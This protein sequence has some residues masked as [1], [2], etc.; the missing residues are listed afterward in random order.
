MANQVENPFENEKP[1]IVHLK[2]SE[3]HYEYCR[4]QM[5][6]IEHTHRRTFFANFAICIIVCILAVFRVYVGGFGILSKPYA[7]LGNSEKV[8][9]F[10]ESGAFLAGGI[11]QIMIGM[12]VILL[13]YLAW[14]NFHSLNII[15]ETWYVVVGVSGI[16]KG[17]YITGI[18]GAVGAVFYFFSLRAMGREQS[19]SEMD[20]YP[21]F[22]EKFD[23]SKSDIVIQTLLAHKG[24]HRTKSTLFT[25]DYSLRRKKKKKNGAEDAP[26]ADP[27]KELAEMLQKRLDE[28]RTDEANA[29]SK[30]EK[31]DDAQEKL[32]ETEA[33][34]PEQQPEEAATA[35][36]PEAVPETEKAAP[37]AEV[38]EAADAKAEADAILAEAE[39]KAKAI[40]AEAVAKAQALE[41]KPQ[42]QPEA[43]PARKQSGT[44]QSGGGNP[45]HRKK[46]KK[47]Q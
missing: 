12:V 13:G 10:V 47:P 11:F 33:E 34:A 22:Q 14:A 21:D 1:K 6:E 27:G 44:N 20:G 45:Q 39:A 32:T 2:K 15:L 7:V 38:S 18:I 4:M 42:A 40:L 37:E 9:R 35:A 8:S 19:L 3:S 5:H 36:E 25:T 30:Q 41:Q 31:P 23:L 17:D 29:Q 16:F 24:E 46:K 43:A 28:K 26:E